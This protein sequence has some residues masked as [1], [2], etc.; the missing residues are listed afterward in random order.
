MD[1]NNLD[2]SSPYISVII[3]I[4]NIPENIL[5]HCIDSVVNQTLRNIQIILVNDGSTDNSPLICDE[6]A[7]ADDRIITIHKINGGVS[8]ARNE[9]LKIATATYIAFVDA[10]DWIENT[11]FERV[12]KIADQTSIDCLL[13]DYSVEN[14]K[15]TSNRKISI[16]DNIPVE[17]FDTYEGIE[18]LQ[19]AMIG[20][21]VNL[22]GR[23]GIKGTPYCKLYKKSIIDKHS[24][25]FNTNLPRSQDN[26]FNFRYFQFVK[27]AAYVPIELYY[28]R[29]IQ[30]SATHMYRQNAV[31]E[32]DRF[33]EALND[34]LKLFQKGTIF[35]KD[36]FYIRINKFADICRTN[37]AHPDNPY[38]IYERILSIKQLAESEEYSKAIKE[39]RIMQ[40]KRILILVLPLLK[41]KCYAMVYLLFII[42]HRI[43]N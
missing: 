23:K 28:Y 11:A 6:Y 7:K 42:R 27:K 37:F 25:Y 32:F 40:M 9:G 31:S 5:R 39:C 22:K 30:S 24:I 15:K 14:R 38:G 16:N 3:P 19:R 18:F 20:A 10:D 21:N 4:Y 34:D 1:I 17:Y 35:S 12:K 43:K 29:Q 33:F 36:L 41:L 2:V 26:E 13:W 8:T